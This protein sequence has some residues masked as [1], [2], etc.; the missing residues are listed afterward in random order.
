[1]SMMEITPKNR[2][3]DLNTLN[4]VRES[5]EEQRVLKYYLLF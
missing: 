2:K 5:F 3:V 1:M 4:I